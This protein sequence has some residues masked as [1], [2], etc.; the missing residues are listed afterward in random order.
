VAGQHVARVGR[1]QGLERRP[2]A[3]A[4]DRRRARDQPRARAL[5]EARDRDG[6]PFAVDGLSAF[7]EREAA[8]G[9][10]APETLRRLRQTIDAE[11][12]DGLHDDATA[13][14][15]EW[16]RDNETALL[17]PTVGPGR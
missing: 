3:R 7:V 11:Q 8:S 12:P 13:L 17:P 15:V 16:N 14:L 1:G 5:T 2:V 6:R 10:P 9:Q 4:V